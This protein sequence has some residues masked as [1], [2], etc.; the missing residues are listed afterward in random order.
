M[1][2]GYSWNNS[3]ML[4]G[5]GAITG[6]SSAIVAA[7]YSARICMRKKMMMIAA[8]TIIIIFCSYVCAHVLVQHSGSDGAGVIIIFSCIHMR[9]CS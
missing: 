1:Q 9:A 3:V 2:E 7:L 8:R 5:T 6:L 4:R